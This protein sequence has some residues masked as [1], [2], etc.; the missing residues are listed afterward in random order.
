MVWFGAAVLTPGNEDEVRKFNYMNKEEGFYFSLYIND[1]LF[2]FIS[3]P[4]Y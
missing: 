2:S 3:P 4:G 1:G